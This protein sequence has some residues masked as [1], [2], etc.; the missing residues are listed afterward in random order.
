MQK[1]SDILELNE[2]Q[3]QW[4]MIRYGYYILDS[5][6]WNDSSGLDQIVLD[7][8]ESISI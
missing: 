5:V 8:L 1:L 3:Y 7:N 2:L 4:Q 6:T